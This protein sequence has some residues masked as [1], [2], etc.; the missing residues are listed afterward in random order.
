MEHSRIMLQKFQIA[1]FAVMGLGLGDPRE[2]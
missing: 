2:D 1:V